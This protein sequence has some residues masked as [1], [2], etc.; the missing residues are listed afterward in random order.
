VISTVQA[1]SD[2][3]INAPLQDTSKI[4]LAQAKAHN[5][6]NGDP[7]SV[8]YQKNCAACHQ[9]DGQGRPNVIP[10]LAGSDFIRNDPWVL[11]E[12]TLV[13]LSDPLTVSDDD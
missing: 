13:G 4:V 8:L 7:P 1:Q 10:P 9:A 11:V 6:N 12:A 5:G 3:D 2:T